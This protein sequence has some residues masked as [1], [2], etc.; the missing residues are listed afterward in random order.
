[1]E[2]MIGEVRMF[3]GN[4]APRAWALC[5]G[6]LLPISQN[7][8]LFSI[9]GTIYGGDGRTTFALP[10]VRG[11]AVISP[12]T[13]PG[14]PTYRE[15]QRS[16]TESH[17]LLTTEMASHNHNYVNQASNN[18]PFSG[19]ASNPSQMIV[20]P[21]LGNATDVKRYSATQNTA[22]HADFFVVG[23][24]GGSIPF[25]IMMPSLAVNYIICMQGIFPTRS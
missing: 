5:D 2:G 25:D 14:L 1:M 12:G 10:D 13:G 6:Q 18:P 16:G 9:L 4:F 24:A 20:T 19:Q 8:A 23:N 17:T 11:R 3:G 15:G 21:S 22:M 7:T